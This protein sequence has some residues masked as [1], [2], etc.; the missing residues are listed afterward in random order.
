MSHRFF[1]LYVFAGTIAFAVLA[2]QLSAHYSNLNIIALLINAIPGIV[3]Y[4]LA[5]KVSRRHI[6]S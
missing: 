6:E 2:Y 1:F 5:Y 4:Y 3:L